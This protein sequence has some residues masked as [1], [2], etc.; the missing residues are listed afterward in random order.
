MVLIGATTENPFFEV[1]SAL[2]S[3]SRIVELTPFQRENLAEIIAR[4]LV[5]DRGSKGLYSLDDEARDAIL[6]L[7]DGDARS[8][9]NTLSLSSDLARRKGQT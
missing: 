8:A 6:L 3:R 1:N 7:A 9:L 5:N 4:A 2:I